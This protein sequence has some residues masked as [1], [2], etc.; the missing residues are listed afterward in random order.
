MSKIKNSKM[1]LFGLGIKGLLLLGA[2][3]SYVVQAMNYCHATRF[4]YALNMLKKGSLDSFI[5]MSRYHLKN[6]KYQEIEK[7]RHTFE[8]YQSAF[9][10]ARELYQNKELQN[11]VHHMQAEVAAMPVQPMPEPGAGF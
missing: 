7:L 2:V 8:D 4:D 5:K 10:V 9:N 11:L 3:D 1:L 6:L